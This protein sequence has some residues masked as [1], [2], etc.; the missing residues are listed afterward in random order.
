MTDRF[1]HVCFNCGSKTSMGPYAVD[2]KETVV[3]PACC[4]RDGCIEQW[5]H[6]PLAEYKATPLETLP[7]YT[8]AQIFAGRTTSPNPQG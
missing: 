7:H 4:A 3:W 2:G 6:V 5:W 1:I 8:V